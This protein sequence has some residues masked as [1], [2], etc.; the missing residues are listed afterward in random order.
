MRDDA[1]AMPGR[2]SCLA[3]HSRQA[4]QS[5][6]KPPGQKVHNGC[7]KGAVPLDVV[8]RCEIAMRCLEGYDRDG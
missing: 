6:G 3:R 2:M 7:K 4:G 5:I 1:R 8:A